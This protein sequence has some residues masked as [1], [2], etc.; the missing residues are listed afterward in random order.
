MC[1]HPFFYVCMFMLFD[2]FYTMLCILPFSFHPFL[3]CKHF[4]MLLKYF[5]K[6]KFNVCI[7]LPLFMGYILINYSFLIVYEVYL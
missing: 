3:D 2:I 5:Y 4:P 6:H 7:M 1:F